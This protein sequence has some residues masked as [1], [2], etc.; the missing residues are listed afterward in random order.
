MEKMLNL[1]VL[2]WLLQLEVSHTIL[3]SH[4]HRE[5]GPRRGL[6][7][8][9]TQHD[10]IAYLCQKARI[11]GLLAPSLFYELPEDCVSLAII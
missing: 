7:Y 5:A 2:P 1:G 3:K 11:S 8:K 6:T 4:P 10:A 9:V